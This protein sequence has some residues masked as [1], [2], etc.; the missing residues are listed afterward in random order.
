MNRPNVLLLHCHDLGR[1]LGC[2]GVATVRTPHLDRF[3]AESVVFDRAFSVAPQ[4]SPARA[5]LLTGMYPQEVGVLGLTHPPFSWDLTRPD[6]HLAR[7]LRTLGYRTE[8]YGVHHES[9]LAPDEVVAGDLGFDEVQ[10]GGVADDVADRTIGALRRLKEEGP[11]YLQV[12]FVEPHR[13]QSSR[14][15]EGVV[16]FLGE[17]IAPDDAQGVTVPPYVRDT[18]QA[19]AEFAE[20]QGA[21]RVMDA[22]VGRILDAL[23]RLRL[24]Q[25]TVVVFTTDHGIAV[26]RAKCSL[27]E[28]GLEVALMLR[29]P[30][31]PDQAGTR[32]ED[33][34]SHLSVVPTVLDIVG[35]PDDALTEPSLL[36]VAG[37]R[38]SD[39]PLV[40]GQMTYHSYY[41]PKRSARDDRFK[42]ILNF[43]NA[44]LAMDPTQ[45]WLHRSIPVGLDRGNVPNSAAVE[46]YDLDADPLE[47]DNLADDERH[48]DRLAEMMTRLRSWMVA[49]G[50]PLLQGSVTPPRHAELLARVDSAV[51][52]APS[53]G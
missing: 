39:H 18:P 25:S 44:P 9:R 20:L 23:R 2:Y 6:K 7:R 14:D 8:L 38:A 42:L 46:F 12:G 3:A 40:F 4:C 29:D 11:F 21:V 36:D 31:R 41:D 28:A 10:T 52:T 32:V 5:S 49:T 48:R 53:L 30:S 35:A 43:S 19:Q 24:E 26:P 16:G 33:L 34:V 17:H 22:A 50:D 47:L 13:L 37:G 51:G 45:S 1:F 15:T 27:Y